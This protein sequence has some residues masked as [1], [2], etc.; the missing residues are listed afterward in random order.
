MIKL[1]KRALKGLFS[2]WNKSSDTPPK[3]D[4]EEILAKRNILVD[5]FNRLDE[6]LTTKCREVLYNTSKSME[7]ATTEQNLVYLYNSACKKL[8]DLEV[9][10]QEIDD[11][12]ISIIVTNNE[13]YPYGFTG[14]T[15]RF[16]QHST[17]TKLLLREKMDKLRD[18]LWKKDLS[19][20]AEY[21]R[22]KV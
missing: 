2:I 15:T 4:V 20:I 13:L 22:G 6:E 11:T 3:E 14:F 16:I 1:F 12:F 8:D 5:K 10:E 18:G 17:E 19:D 21:F 7:N 9:L